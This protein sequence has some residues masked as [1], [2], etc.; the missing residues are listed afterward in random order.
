MDNTCISCGR[1]IPEGS[2]ICLHCESE[3]D[4]QTFRQRIQTNG[5]RIRAMTNKELVQLGVRLGIVPEWL[6]AAAL[7]WLESEAKP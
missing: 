6:D 1:V 2:I 3:N 4:M 7:E 5:D